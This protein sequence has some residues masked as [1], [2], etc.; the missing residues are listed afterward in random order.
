MSLLNRWLFLL[1]GV[2]LVPLL[3]HG[4]PAEA[5]G[6]AEIKGSGVIRIGIREDIAPIQYRDKRGNWSASTRIS[7]GPWPRHSA[8]NRSG[9][10]SPARSSAKSCCLR[11][12]W[13]S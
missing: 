2:G 10:S 3:L 8:S 11:R 1:M 7:G 5:R 9:P 4:S 6:L 13:T 12:R